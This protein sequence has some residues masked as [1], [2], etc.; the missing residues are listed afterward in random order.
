M[1][2]AYNKPC[3]WL[4]KIGST[5]TPHD[6]CVVP[7]TGIGQ[8]MTPW[9]LDILQGLPPYQRKAHQLDASVS[10]R[11]YVT[12]LDNNYPPYSRLTLYE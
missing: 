6:G 11:V 12:Y 3:S 9:L 8:S 1:T 7:N 4:P 5:D 10:L 2:T